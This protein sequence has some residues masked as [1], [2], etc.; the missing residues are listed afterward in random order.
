MVSSSLIFTSLRQAENSWHSGWPWSIP[1]TRANSVQPCQFL[2]DCAA[3]ANSC[4]VA[5]LNWIVGILT[6]LN[7]TAGILTMKIG[8]TPKNYF[9]RD[10]HP[11]VLF[12]IFSPPPLDSG[13][14]V[15]GRGRLKHLRTVY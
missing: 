1:L 7:W 6:L 4:L 12:T 14:E 15:C 13:L 5:L 3:V 10:P 9:Y 8:I 2:L 11:L